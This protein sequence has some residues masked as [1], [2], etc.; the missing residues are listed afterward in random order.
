MSDTDYHLC[1]AS[2][3]P[4]RGEL[5]AQ[6]GVRFRVEVADT[7]ETPRPDESPAL[8]VRRV[9]LG[10]ARAVVERSA[11][12]VR[13]PV[14]AAD[15]AVVLGERILGKPRDREDALEMLRALSGRSHRVLSAI[16]LISS[17]HVHTDLSESC[18]TFRQIEEHEM[19]HYWQTREPCDKAGGY[20]IQG[21]GAL[22]VAH[23]QGSYSG[24]MGLPLFETGR[25]LEAAGITLG[26]T[27]IQTRLTPDT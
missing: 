11:S 6:I 22:F 16:A 12:S 9:A 18:V 5:L 27:S 4:R 21:L 25:L 14:L 23:L 3:S 7:D 8:Y 20:A 24:V 2:R 15:T 19:L 10:K 17:G 26:Q 13:L 1:L